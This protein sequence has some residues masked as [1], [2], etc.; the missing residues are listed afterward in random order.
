M[1]NIFVR[2]NVFAKST[3]ANDIRNFVKYKLTT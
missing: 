1:L 2:V 3:N